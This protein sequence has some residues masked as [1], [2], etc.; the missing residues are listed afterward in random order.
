MT[1]EQ[2]QALLDTYSGVGVEAKKDTGETLYFFFQDFNYSGEG[3]D[4]AMEMLYPLQSQGVI[5][6]L[7]FIG[8]RED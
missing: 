1:K 5:T 8:K 3:V 2:M 7:T 4:T 6:H